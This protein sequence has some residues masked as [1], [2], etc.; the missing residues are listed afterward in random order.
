M[1]RWAK[2]HFHP[3]ASI[4]SLA[5]DIYVYIHDENPTAT[6]DHLIMS[7]RCQG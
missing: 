1:T 3:I 2:E 5:Q 7:W 4:S 6:A